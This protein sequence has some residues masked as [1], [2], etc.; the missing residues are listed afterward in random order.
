MT[1]DTIV[2]VAPAEIDF[3]D[4][5]DLGT[6]RA[7]LVTRH[8]CVHLHRGTWHW[9]PYPVAADAVRI[10]NVQGRGYTSDNTVARITERFGVMFGVRA[11]A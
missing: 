2:V 6:V 8:T 7:F 11:Q 3:S 5:A 4:P 1:A 10:F 9:G